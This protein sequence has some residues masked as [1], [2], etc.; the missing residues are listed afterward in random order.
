MQFSLEVMI[1]CIPID[2]S[3]AKQKSVNTHLKDDVYCKFLAN[4]QVNLDTFSS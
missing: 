1:V 3:D 4:T 2:I